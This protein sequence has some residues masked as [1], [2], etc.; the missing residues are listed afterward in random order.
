MPLAEAFGTVGKSL[1]FYRLG[2]MLSATSDVNHRPKLD[3]RGGRPRRTVLLLF[4]L[5][6]SVADVNGR[7][8]GL[9]AQEDQQSTSHFS[10]NSAECHACGCCCHGNA[11]VCNAPAGVDPRG[12]KCRRVRACVC[13]CAGGLMCAAMPCV[14]WCEGDEPCL[15][16]SSY[17]GVQLCVRPLC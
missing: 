13:V 15:I 6:S 8:C 2:L 1:F 7:L 5:S 16:V 17:G 9:N 11:T 10:V 3:G 12:R 4:R 14:Y